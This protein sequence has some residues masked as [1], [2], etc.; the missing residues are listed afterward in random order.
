YSAAHKQEEKI[1]GM[2]KQPADAA[3]KAQL[4]KLRTEVAGDL[5]DYLESLRMGA[6]YYKTSLGLVGAAP[7][8]ETDRLAAQARREYGGRGVFDTHMTQNIGVLETWL[9]RTRSKGA[10]ALSVRDILKGILPE[11]HFRILPL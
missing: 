5:K 4:E 10:S 8:E 9:A 7:K 1:R 3:T 6:G 2:L 11:Q